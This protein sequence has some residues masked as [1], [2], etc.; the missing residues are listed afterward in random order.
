MFST[1]KYGLM[2]KKMALILL[3]LASFYLSD[4]DGLRVEEQLMASHKALSPNQTDD[5]TAS[6]VS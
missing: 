5:I 6:S 4:C 1:G 2:R 3:L